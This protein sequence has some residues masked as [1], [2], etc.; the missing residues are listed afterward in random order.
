M[1]PELLLAT[2]L[3]DAMRNNFQLMRA[4]AEHTR[5]DPLKRVE[6]LMKFNNRLNTTEKSKEQFSQFHTKL[7]S[8]LVE[9]TGRE[10]TQENM[11]FGEGKES[12]NDVRNVDWTNAMKTACML[13]SVDLTRW[14]IISPKRANTETTKFL[15]L[16]GEVASGMKYTMGTPKIVEIADDRVTTYANEL[17]KVLRLDPKFI[18]IVLPNANADRYAT[19][20]K[21]TCVQNAIPTQVVVH[22][23]MMPK[24]GN[25]GGVKSVATKVLIQM[26]C[27]L[28]GAAWTVKIPLSGCMTVGFDVTHDSTDKRKSFGA[29]VAALD[30]KKKVKFFSS[31]SSHSNGEECSNNITIHM[32]KALMSYREEYGTLPEKI[33]FYRDGVGDGDIEY[34]NKIEVANLNKLFKEVYSAEGLT[35]KFCFIIVNKRINVRIFKS[36]HGNRVENPPSGTVVDNTI[37]QP[38]RYDFYLIS[39]SVRQ[40]TVSPTSYNIIYDNMG[41][42]PDKLQILTYKNCHL[43]YNW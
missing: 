3:T 8:E 15:S 10:I 20:K 21:I 16:L 28:G 29:F 26:N 2:G 18:M 39:Q 11:F 36:V 19:I 43:Y 6:R 5:L 25:W 9:F 38:E 33:L 30:I 17:Q 27:K 32:Q 42:P 1:V 23:T 37:T 41:L 35:P 4:M 40:G 34:V 12:T 22:K 13:R 7:K 24:N 31:V 14:I